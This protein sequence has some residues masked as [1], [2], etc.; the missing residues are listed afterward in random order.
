VLIFSRLDQIA[1]GCVPLNQRSYRRAGASVVAVLFAIALAGCSTGRT[2]LE[3]SA[4]DVYGAESAD[5]EFWDD[6]VKRRVVTNNDA[7]HGLLLV[8]D[9]KDPAKTYAQRIAVAQAKGW[10]VGTRTA[11]INESATAG[12]IGVATCEILKLKGGL[13]IQWLGANPRHCLREIIHHELMPH[14]TA[15]Q[16]LSGLEFTDL[17]NRISH[18]QRAVKKAAP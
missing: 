17:V 1:G 11:L 5:F 7:L 13:S 18:Y 2:I 14:R 9:G 3:N 10:L 12:M 8:A 15:G 6:L 4:A 16:S